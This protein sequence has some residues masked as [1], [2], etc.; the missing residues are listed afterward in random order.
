MEG[1]SQA[2]KNAAVL[3]LALLFTFPTHTLASSVIMSDNGFLY[4]QGGFPLGAQGDLLAGV[5]Y[6]S[7]TV[8]P[9]NTDLSQ[10]ELT[11]SIGGLILADQFQYGAT[12]YTNYSGGTIKISLDPMMNGDYGTNPPNAISP[13]T[14]EDGEPFLIGTIVTTRMTYNT[15][16]QNGVLQALVNFTNGTALP[17]LPQPNGNIV[18]FTFGPDDPNIPTGYVLQVIGKI[19][20]PALCAVKGNVSITP[21]GSPVAGVTIDLV[22]GEG[23]IRGTLTGADGNYNFFDVAIS[24]ITVSL[25]VPLGYSAVTPSLVDLVCAPGD[26]AIVNFVLQRIPTQDTPRSVGFW[27]HQVT[28]ALSGKQKGVQVPAAELMSLFAQIHSRFDQYYSVFVP[29]VTLE[30]FYDVLSA[31]GG[32][33]YEKGRMQYAALLLNVVSNRL[34]TWQFISADQATV[35]QAIT[36][37]GTLL[38]DSDLS[39]DELAKDISEMIVNGQ[40]VGAGLIPLTISQIAYSSPKHAGGGDVPTAIRNVGNYPNPFNPMTTI[41]YELDREVP[42]TL[43]IYNVLGQKVRDLVRGEIQNGLNEVKW[44][45]HDNGGRGLGSGIYFYRLM[46]GRE[47]VTHR[48]VLIR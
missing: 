38:T 24:D 22:D 39:N 13:A 46:A 21:D 35:S 4:V 37:V 3:V 18:E 23:N 30:E 48:I 6:V 2:M 17:D 34:A 29:V 27:K 31:K 25:V 1:G 45:G 36:F 19:T 28:C 47:V 32:T 41:T 10:N 33:M 26:I 12:V 42:V 16:R 20:A 15:V 40:T 14:F 8:P 43:A 11:W 44:D 5:G 9:L 7:S